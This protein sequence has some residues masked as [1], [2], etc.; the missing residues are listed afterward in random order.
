MEA[1]GLGDD[2]R[3]SLEDKLV[4]CRQAASNGGDAEVMD[5]RADR[6]GGQWLAGAAAGEQPGGITIRGC[7]HVGALVT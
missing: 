4:Q 6:A 5:E 1:K 2:R 7:A 3:R